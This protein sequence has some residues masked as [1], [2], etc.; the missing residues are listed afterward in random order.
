MKHAVNKIRCK[1]FTMSELVTVMAIV[2]IIT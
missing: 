2:G 1:A